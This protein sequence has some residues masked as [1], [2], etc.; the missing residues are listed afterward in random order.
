MAKKSSGVIIL[1]I[2]I[3]CL[4]V[5][6]VTGVIVYYTD[7]ACSIGFGADCPPTD[8]TSGT[9]GASGSGTGGASGSGT[10]GASG[11]GTG[12]APAPRTPGAPAPRTPGAPA[13]RTGGSPAPVSGGS[14]AP[15]SG[16]SPA[17][18]SGGSPV[19][20]TQPPPGA[21]CQG[22]WSGYGACSASCGYATK[23]RTFTATTNAMGGGQSCESKYGAN[24]H[25]PSSSEQEVCTGLPACVTASP[26]T[27]QWPTTWS[28]CSAACG[29][30]TQT[31]QF[32]I[33]SAA[34]NGGQE[35][36][37]TD[38]TV[39]TNGNALTAA[40]TKSQ[41]CNSTSCCSSA[42]VG[43][44]QK[45]GSTQCSGRSSGKPEQ[46]WFRN[47]VFPAGTPVNVTA[48]S[49]SINQ[50]ATTY[51]SS[52]CAEVTPSAGS[53][54]GGRTWSSTTGCAGTPVPVTCPF[55]WQYALVGYNSTDDKCHGLNTDGTVMSGGSTTL[56]TCPTNYT[57]NGGTCTPPAQTISSLTCPDY[58]KNP[59]LT[60]NK[61]GWSQSAG[62]SAPAA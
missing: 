8:E 61:C 55:M 38:G 5:A 9:G 4:V 27:G 39:L 48:T 47:I 34:Q 32:V 56:P 60:T 35:C 18:V 49:C 43:A 58:W 7:A 57:R 21:D 46:D 40:G 6:V 54:S 45:Y 23:T 26:C 20:I 30:G 11:S 29:G 28:G 33:T 10:P 36:R 59:N 51:S 31:K 44:W 62:D 2:C 12:G 22:S 25:Y 24:A 42:T 17:P 16:G 37:D 15:V 52:G 53:C 1:I 14:P 41:A 3:F 19:L 50:T 13:P